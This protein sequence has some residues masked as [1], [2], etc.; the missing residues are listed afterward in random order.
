MQSQVVTV[1][2]V[3]D[4]LRLLTESDAF[5]SNLLVEGEVTEVYLSKAGHL[6][7]TLSDGQASLKAVAFRNATAFNDACPSEIVKYR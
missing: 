2:Q 4:Y 6:Y 7:F 3:S 1:S 5:L